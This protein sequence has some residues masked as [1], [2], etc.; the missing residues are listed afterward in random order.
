MIK[1]NLQIRHSKRL[2][3]ITNN[4]NRTIIMIYC[5]KSYVNVVSL[6]QN[7]LLCKFNAFSILAK[8]LS[9]TVTVNFC[10]LRCK[11]KTSTNFLFLLNNFT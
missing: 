2:T 4:K 1:F 3:M 10:R 8:H 7:I 9:H 6:S 5:N 11:S